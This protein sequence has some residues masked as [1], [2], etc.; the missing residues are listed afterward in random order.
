MAWTDTELAELAMCSRYG[1]TKAR[2]DAERATA[3]SVKDAHLK[4][5]EL[6]EEMARR[7]EAARKRLQEQERQE[8]SAQRR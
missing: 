7:L 5:A 1:A 3:V 8:L 4:T 2:E 6:R